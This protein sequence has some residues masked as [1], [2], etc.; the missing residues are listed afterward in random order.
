LDVLHAVHH[1]L[2]EKS[3]AVFKALEALIRRF[4]AVI[5]VL[6]EALAEPVDHTV[7]PLFHSFEV[8]S[9]I[10][11]HDVTLSSSI[12]LI[13]IILNRSSRDALAAVPLDR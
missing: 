3:K 1:A 12:D 4:A 9:Q 7:K 5:R 8:A 13:I 2:L 11:I 10:V 6:D